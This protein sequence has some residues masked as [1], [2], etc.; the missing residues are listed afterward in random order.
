MPTTHL[1][2]RAVI[3]REGNVLVVRADGQSHT[4]LPGG[5]HEACEGMEVCLQRELRE[6]LGI[7]STV[8]RYL[9]AV[10]H[11]WTRNGQLHYEIN[12]CFAVTAPTLTLDRRPRPLEEHLTFGWIPLDALDEVA[13]QPAPLRSLLA[14]DDRDEPWWASTLNAVTVGTEEK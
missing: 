7:R 5:H 11:E 8:E 14:K 9:G 13:L 12:H 1:L 2:A 4:F 10:E 6:E 3:R